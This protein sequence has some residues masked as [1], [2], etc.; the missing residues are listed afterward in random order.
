MTDQEA[1]DKYNKMK[2]WFG[3]DLA[4]F[5]HYPK[6]FA[7]QVKLFDYYMSRKDV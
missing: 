6:Q 1:L 4:N 5:E 3:E 7:F 2:E